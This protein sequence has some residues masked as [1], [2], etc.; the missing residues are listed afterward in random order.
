MKEATNASV[1]RSTSSLGV[2]ELAQ[3]SVDDHADLVGERGG[4]LE[5]VRDEHGRQRELVQQLL[6]L[7]AHGAL[8]VRV[9]CGER[10]VEQDH[11]R[12]AGERAGERDPLALAARERGRPARR[13]AGRSG[14]A[15]GTRRRAPCRA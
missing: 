5:V 11:P 7:G 1:G 15:R 2:R 8:R 14:T 4:V 9:E 3:A 12:A 6:E 13:R 10:L